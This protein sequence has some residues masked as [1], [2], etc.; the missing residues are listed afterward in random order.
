MINKIIKLKNQKEYVIA[1][2]CDYQ[3]QHYYFAC[4]VE[5]DDDT[6]NFVVLQVIE[7]NG[8]RIV[9]FIKD[10]TIVKEVCAIIDAKL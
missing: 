10:D 2:E 7:K 5:N 9:K 4:E 6:D 1:E 8:K 3:N